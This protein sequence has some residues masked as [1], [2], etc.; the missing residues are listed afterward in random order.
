MKRRYFLT[1][2]LILGAIALQAAGPK[3][4][5]SADADAF[6]TL[7]TLAGNWQS[8]KVDP[9][10]G[11]VHLSYEV[12]AAGTAVVER[13][14]GEKMPEMLT[15]YHLD[16]GH[17]MLTHYCMAGNQP[18][19]QMRTFSPESGELQ[20]K[21]LDGTNLKPGDGHMHNAT[22]RVAAPNRLITD[23]EFYEN[24]QRKFE[25]SAEYTRLP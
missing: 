23:W 4:E 13:T 3:A 5:R 6:A 22:L 17:L 16:G 12:I 20:F 24:G 11:R 7:K 21:F 9:K 15:V 14:T 19:M 1:A 18:R 8:E 10:M 2:G 25:E